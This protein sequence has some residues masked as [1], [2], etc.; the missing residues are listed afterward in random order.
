MKHVFYALFC[1]LFFGFCTRLTGLSLFEMY[2]TALLLFMGLATLAQLVIWPRESVSLLLRL[3]RRELLSGTE[4]QRLLYHLRFVG[5]TAL[6]YCL[7]LILL[8]AFSALGAVDSQRSM[9]TLGLFLSVALL[10]P[11]AYLLLQLWVLQP[12]VQ[13]IEKQKAASV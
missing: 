9:V 5:R 6:H 10:A 1:L 8:G 12:L 4:Q 7:L 3:L 2:D 13:A 11:L